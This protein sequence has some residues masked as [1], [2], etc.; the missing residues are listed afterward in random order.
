MASP[1][2]ETHPVYLTKHKERP[3]G[4]GEAQRTK[5]LFPK[6]PRITSAK[7]YVLI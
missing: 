3:G 1:S 6:V 4:G 5:D 7:L 2:S